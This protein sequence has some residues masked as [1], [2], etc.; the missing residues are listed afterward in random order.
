VASGQLF[1]W[2]ALSDEEDTAQEGHRCQA[3]VV[4]RRL[5]RN[6]AQYLGDVQAP[7]ERAA[8]TAA[9][10]E[11]NLSDEQRKRLVVQERE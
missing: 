10:A 1:I 9:V 7:D 11:F 5:L 6:R 2:R 3:A 8:E 4:A